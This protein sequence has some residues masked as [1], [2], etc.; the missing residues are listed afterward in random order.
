MSAEVKVL[1]CGSIPAMI[2]D[3]EETV[4]SWFY[5]FHFLKGEG[6]G[7]CHVCGATVGHEVDGAED[8]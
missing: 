3:G 6:V 2:F 7:K 5:G 1:Y 8:A 4:K